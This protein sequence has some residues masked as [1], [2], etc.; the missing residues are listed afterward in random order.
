MG[1]DEN[2]GSVQIDMSPFFDKGHVSHSF[3]L[4]NETVTSNALINASFKVV[5]IEDTANGRAKTRS[6]PAREAATTLIPAPKNPLMAS[7][8]DKSKFP[9]SQV[10]HGGVKKRYQSVVY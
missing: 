1:K 9:Q 10:A 6:P 2:T 5:P 8:D 4:N 7:V 3:R